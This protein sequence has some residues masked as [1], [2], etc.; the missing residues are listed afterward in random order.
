M[1]S[2]CQGQ[3]TESMR[4][5]GSF[6]RWMPGA[7]CDQLV[8]SFACT[9]IRA[10]LSGGSVPA[11]SFTSLPRPNSVPLISVG[12][13]VPM[14]DKEESCRV[15]KA[16]SPSSEP[17]VASRGFRY[18]EHTADIGIVAWG[19]SLAAAFEAAAE[20]L[21]GLLCEIAEVREL[22]C[23]EIG[24]QAQDRDSLLVNWLNEIN[25][26]FE[27]DRHV[28]RRF[29]IVDLRSTALSARAW[30][31]PLAPRRH[32]PGE[33]VKAVTYHGLRIDEAPGRC[34][35]QVIVDI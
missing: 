7:A 18:L 35:V 33:Q 19:Q 21:T 24:V 20:A 30:G 10:C 14:T 29:E 9:G 16:A 25:F 28:F 15:S 23:E 8:E 12:S 31:E 22:E 11:R 4:I 26:R 27:A 3:G 17:A 2:K 34:E 32:H 5:Q 13:I 6:R 1:H